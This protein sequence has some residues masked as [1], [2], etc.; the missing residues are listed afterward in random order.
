[1]SLED[2]E[3][4]IVADAIKS[5]T[6]QPVPPSIRSLAESMGLSV[7]MLQRG[8]KAAGIESVS[9]WIAEQHA[10]AKPVER[11]R[12]GPRVQELL[13]DLMRR[14]EDARPHVQCG[15]C[16]SFSFGPHE[17]N[18]IRVTPYMVWFMMGARSVMADR[19]HATEAWVEA[20]RARQADRAE[21]QR[22]AFERLRTHHTYV[23]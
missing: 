14:E 12:C 6:T 9:A 16:L 21:R 4:L 10:K 1:M 23:V 17:V 8:L 20:W 2:T 19:T 5:I 3:L 22:M 7:G 13:R 11:L 18:T 15:Q